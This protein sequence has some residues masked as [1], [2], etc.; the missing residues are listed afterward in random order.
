M[1]AAGHTRY[2]K[3]NF[4]VNPSINNK[5]DL[6]FLHSAGHLNLIQCYGKLLKSLT[7]DIWPWINSA[8]VFQYFI[9]QV[10]T[11]GISRVSLISDY[12]AL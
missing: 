1:P 8:A 12:L 6:P 9:M 2:T 11:A 4:E 10:R 7:A 3:C 5:N